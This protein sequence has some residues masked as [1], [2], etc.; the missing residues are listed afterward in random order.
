M[1][2]CESG[3]NWA[4]HGY[5]EGGLQFHPDT[6]T[7]YVA[8]GKSYALAGYPA[9]AYDAT[10]EQQIVVAIRVRDGVK[11]SSDPYLN[12]QGYGAWPH[13]RHNVGV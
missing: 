8:A 3:G 12:A 9:H 1:A 10:R 6:W 7:A 11:D 13:C 2:E 5:H 4:K